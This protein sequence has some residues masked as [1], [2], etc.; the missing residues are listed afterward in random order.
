MGLLNN[1]T[2]LL[3]SE[4]IRE[5]RTLLSREIELARTE[6][7]EKVSASIRNSVTL[8]I[9]AIVA[10]AGFLLLLT[11]AVS[12]LSAVMPVWLSALIIGTIV[13]MAGAVF[14]WAALKKLKKMKIGLEHTMS[15][16][17]RKKEQKEED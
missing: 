8:V 14:S 11:A 13:F 15:G 16:I 17:S 4:L 3:F 5:L 1:T 10:Y 2:G 7:S 9:S 12:G 6:I